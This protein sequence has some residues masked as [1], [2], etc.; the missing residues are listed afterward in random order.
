M[1]R[2]V[3]ASAAAL[4]T[5]LAL[6]SP[7]AA[8]SSAGLSVADGDL[9]VV[10]QHNLAVTVDGGTKLA[11]VIIKLSDAP[12]ASYDGSLS[13]L[14]ATSPAATGT[15]KLDASS[16]AAANY[17]AYLD[18]KQASFERTLASAIPSAR[19]TQRYTMV[20]GGVSALVP[21][22]EISVIS[23]LPG[24]EAV[25]PDDLN[26][27][28]TENSPFFIGADKAWLAAGGQDV[29]G[30]G[31]VV[32]VVDTGVWPEHPSYSDPDP[33]GKA[34]AAPPTGP[35]PCE[36][37]SAVPGDVP[38]TCNNKLIGAY[39]FTA[40][41]QAV[42][43]LLPTEFPSARDDN[44]HGSHTSTTA[45]GNAGVA[46]SILGSDLGVVS[47]IAP[48]AHIVA[49]KACGDLG[50]FTS[51]LV[52]A[53]QQATIDGV[54]VINYSI[55]GGG[56]PYSDAAS[57]AF[58]D[59]FNS[60]VFV[61]ASAG[62]SGPGADT[63]AHR[64]P[65]T[66][67]VGASTQDRAFLGTIALE[68]DNADTLT[69]TGAS[70]TGGFGPA[71]VVLASDFGD[72]LCL[73][74][75]AP[76]TF[77]GEIVVC[78]RG[79]IARVSKSFNAAEGGAGGFVLYNPTFQGTATDNHF[80]PGVHLEDD[81][82]ADLLDFMAT[83]T[84]VTGTLSGGS[85]APSQGDAMASFSSRGGTGQSLGISKPDVTNVG[86]Q[87]LAAN[88]PMPATEVGGVPGEFFQVIQGT[89]MSS[90]HTAGAGALLVQLHPD[91]SPAQIKSALMM[92][93]TDDV[94]KEDGVTP[95]DT[96]DFGSGRVDL[97][98]AFDPS[99]TMDTDA[100]DFLTY[101]DNLWNANYPSI[102]I[103]VMPGH[104]TVPRTVH[105][106][107]GRWTSW[108]VTVDAPPDVDISVPLAGAGSRRR[109]RVPPHGDRTF[110]VSID[111]RDVPMGEARFA[112][113]TLRRGG[114]KLHI[115]VTIVRG[116][117]SV[118]QTLSCDPLVF[119]VDD[120]TDC[121][122]TVENT[123]L[124]DAHV[125][126]TLIVPRPLRIFSPSVSGGTRVGR[127]GII[128][129]DTLAGAQPPAP[130]MVDGVSPAGYL[131]L[132]DFGVT[133]IS[134]TSDESITNFAV[135]PFVFAGETYTTIGM[136]S[137]GYAVVGGGD[138]SDVDFINQIL[139]DPARPNNVLAPF[140]T[141]LNP[142]DGGNMYAASLT[143]GV[144][145][146]LILEWE[147]IQDFGDGV[148]NSFQIWIGTN[149]VEDISYA[150]GNVGA[151]DGGFLT[152]GVENDTG[153]SGDNW[154]A[155][156]VGTL[157]VAGDD[158][159]VESIPG[160]PGGMLTVSFTAVGGHPGNWRIESFLESDLFEGVSITSAS[161][162]VIR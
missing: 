76:G 29:A 64:E 86:V 43:G 30:E 118:T 46:A 1:S 92:T 145:F 32:G 10:S 67:T 138:G 143:D 157:P 11:S 27:V 33:L 61:S 20:L 116:Q 4:T 158:L 123:S 42:I 155:D 26:S 151:G 117:P 15:V 66:T 3:W 68:A 107:L 128:A 109:L 75:F 28:T 125:D 156:G 48:R 154:Y 55:S 98:K 149:G 96:F 65:W 9:T 108:I 16:A 127:F 159:T 25:F 74:P 58:L 12:L 13:G 110:Y 121:T 47:G 7:T 51:D 115:P 101:A 132:A 2:R 49:Y 105:N 80:V 38:F 148:P 31:V 83:H 56:S 19:V 103:P 119:A 79:Q 134:G 140:W 152:V 129:S 87:V 142:E 21:E 72:G 100:V 133:P 34:Y 150:Y 53:I 44:G 91:W 62:N 90:P 126:S 22:N 111:A 131:P 88:T 69:L 45:A 97:S 137:N 89:S 77:S 124:E 144:S 23:T 130:S 41:Y 63:V 94:F 18:A 57:L 147:A 24:V 36:F 95:G 120:A 78:E 162:A 73:S 139:P 71:D 160:A 102:Y 70:V 39:G 52:G 141:D 99:L 17:L 113:M 85:A 50:C 106:E 5:V 84:G 35:L 8:A 81:A 146:W 114:E 60:G 161:G 135:D 40:T 153:T 136:V 82:G 122:L 93:A 37:G 14:P 54:D 59:A 6:L 104:I 112:S